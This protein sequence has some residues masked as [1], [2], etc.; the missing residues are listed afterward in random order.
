MLLLFSF[1]DKLFDFV[2]DCER[3]LLL[4]LDKFMKLL[5]FSLLLESL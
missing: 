2:F 4:S 5:F 1:T 3:K